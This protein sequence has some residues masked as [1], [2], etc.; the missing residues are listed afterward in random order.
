M[1]TLKWLK[2][3]LFAA[4]GLGLMYLAFRNKNP[5]TLVDVLKDVNYSWV[6]LSV[7]FGALAIISRGLRWVIILKSLGFKARKSNSIYAVSIGYFTNIAIPRAGEITRCTSLNQTENIPLDKLFGTIILERAIDF[8]IL[9][10]LLIVTLIMKFELVFK[11]YVAL[12]GELTLNVFSA[13]LWGVGSLTIVFLL[14]YCLG[15]FFKTHRL[16]VKLV[17]I[18]T[19]VLDGFKSIKTLSN[20]H[21]FWLHTIVIWLMY[22]LMTYICFFSIT[23]TRVLS[24]L[25]GLYAMVIGGFGMVAPVQGG[26]GAYHV[27]VTE[28]LV[29]LGISEESSFLFATIVHTAQTLMTLAFGGIS[30]LMVFLSNKKLKS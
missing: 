12:F 4:L 10:S 27:I 25:D 19:G 29:L 7:I 14:F 24:I 16:Y 28:G 3:V 2:Y 21:E 15:L 11:L 13:I 26:F 9:I 23:E 18:L 17:S 1:K 22:V 20:P 6:W 5:K 30:I 8:I